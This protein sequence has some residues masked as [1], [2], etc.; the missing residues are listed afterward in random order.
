MTLYREHLGRFEKDVKVYCAPAKVGKR[1]KADI[2]SHINSR[3]GFFWSTIIVN[4]KTVD[5][6]VKAK[7]GL[8]IQEKRIYNELSICN[9]CVRVS[10]CAHNVQE[11][12]ELV[13]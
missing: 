6:K 7:T 3:A 2:N 1:W 12:L 4:Y 9:K 13:S 8:I 10:G 11:C 5:K